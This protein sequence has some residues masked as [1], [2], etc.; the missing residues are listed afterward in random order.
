MRCV[1]RLE[2]ESYGRRP[3]YKINDN[4]HCLISCSEEVSQP[5]CRC[6]ISKLQTP[7]LIAMITV[8]VCTRADQLFAFCVFLFAVRLVAKFTAALAL[9]LLKSCRLLSSFNTSTDGFPIYSGT[10]STWQTMI[11]R[12]TSSGAFARPACRCAITKVTS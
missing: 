7:R 3:A 4:R 11:L 12:S 1:S 6:L 8:A 10:Y 5:S 2:A 9:C